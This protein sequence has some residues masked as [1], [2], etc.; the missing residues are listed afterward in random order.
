MNGRQHAQHRNDL[1]CNVC[2]ETNFENL[3]KDKSRKSGARNKCNACAHSTYASKRPEAQLLAEQKYRIKQ[4]WLNSFQIVHDPSGIYERNVLF[5]RGDFLDT[6]K[7]GV[8]PEGLIV[9]DLK[10]E[11][12]FRVHAMELKEYND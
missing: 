12:Y 3:R 10:K 6:L 11:K 2:G 4:R 7:A 1:R 8:W 9:H 5:R